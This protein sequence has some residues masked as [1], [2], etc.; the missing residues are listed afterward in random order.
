M[1]SR[2]HPPPE[3]GMTFSRG[4]RVIA[5]DAYARIKRGTIGVIEVPG[6]LF[7]PPR[8]S[9]EDGNSVAYPPNMLAR[10]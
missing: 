6:G 9:F 4:D 1:L 8:V 7:D 10:L 2:S 5:T 3:A